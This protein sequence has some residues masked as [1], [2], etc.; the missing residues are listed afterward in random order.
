M[1][2]FCMQ[3]SQQ[4]LVISFTPVNSRFSVFICCLVYALLLFWHGFSQHSVF[5][6]FSWFVG[7][8]LGAFKPCGCSYPYLK[9]VL[10]NKCYQVYCW[11][12]TLDEL[13]LVSEASA[14]NLRFIDHL[15][16]IIGNILKYLRGLKSCRP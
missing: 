3:Q 1:G 7:C 10:C 15:S 4:S 11:Y 12:Y 2:V 5:N 13:K 14:T 9:S 6:G 16:E 8:E